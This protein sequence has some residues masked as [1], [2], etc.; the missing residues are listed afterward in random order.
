M[1]HSNTYSNNKLLSYDWK[2]RPILPLKFTLRNSKTWKIPSKSPVY[3]RSGP[4][5]QFQLPWCAKSFRGPPPA[6]C[7]R[8]PWP[9]TAS[10]CSPFG[11]KTPTR[12]GRDAAENSGKNKMDF[13][14]ERN[15][16][17]YRFLFLTVKYSPWNSLH[18][19]FWFF[20]Y[21]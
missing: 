10:A 3:H 4:R 13:F 17:L 18:K 2:N 19:K 11:C 9:P 12:D 6:T 5:Q 7:P 21:K 14:E 1:F 15:E 8:C 20:L 16:I